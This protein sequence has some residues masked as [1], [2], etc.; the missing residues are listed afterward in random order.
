MS[1]LEEEEGV[2]FR[3]AA[4]SK[5]IRLTSSGGKATAV[6]VGIVVGEEEEPAGSVITQA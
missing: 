6:E 4:T 3:I 5:A 2:S 1:G